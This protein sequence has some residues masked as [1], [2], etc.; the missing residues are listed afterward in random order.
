MLVHTETVTSTNSKPDHHWL[1][2]LIEKIEQ[3]LSSSDPKNQSIEI[4]DLCM[5]IMSLTDS[6]VDPS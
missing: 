3:R 5:L 2:K 1:I 4:A 6:Q